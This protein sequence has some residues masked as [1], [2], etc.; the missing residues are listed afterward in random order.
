MSEGIGG[1]AERFAPLMALRRVLL[2]W[3][4][5][6]GKRDLRFDLLRGWAV[7]AMVA[8]HIGGARSWLYLLTGGDRFFVSAAEAFVFLSGLLMGLV[9]G[10]LLRRGQ[11]A[12]ALTK[13][14]HRAGTLYAVS[15][16]LTLLTA[17]LPLALGLS[18]APD[19]TDVGLVEY[20]VGV[21]T[22][23]RTAWLTDIP[24]L[25]TLLILAAEPVL[26]LLEHGHTRLVLAA[27]WGL[28]AVWQRWP[29]QA[30]IWPIADN[31]LF[32]VSAWQVLFMTGLVIGY[33]R[34]A[35]DRQF[36]AA[37]GL[38]A[39]LCAGAVLSGALWLHGTGLAPLT[40]LTPWAEAGEVQARLF[41]KAD[42][43]VG[44]LLVFA[45]LSVFAYALVTMAWRPLARALGW[46]LL[47]LGQHALNA[48]VLHLFVVGTLVGLRSRLLGAEPRPIWAN[49]LL[50]LGGIL[51][52]WGLIVLQP[53]LVALVGQWTGRWAITRFGAGVLGQH[54]PLRRPRAG[55][56]RA[57]PGRDRA[58]GSR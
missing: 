30:D 43:R 44:R 3:Q 33:H 56:E 52:V 49:T 57:Q 35:L 37:A 50:Q 13:V 18:W 10:G 15:V 55:I 4:Y 42:V 6:G 34:Q 12:Q 41:A 16:G 23:H 47:P 22:L 20:V 1:G 32:H 29:Q 21:L 38:R 27:S 36:A 8:D 2:G 14:L 51:L 58:A 11:V 40:R 19:V 53:Y 24:L 39:L 54:W 46:L 9:H 5:S 7:V 17:A 31:H 26:L 25:Y 45:A 48:Y 28:W